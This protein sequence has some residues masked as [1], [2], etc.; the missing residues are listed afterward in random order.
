LL[1]LV[2]V[3]AFGEVAGGEL[4]AFVGVVETFEESLLLLVA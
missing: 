2:P 4:P 3:L 1:I